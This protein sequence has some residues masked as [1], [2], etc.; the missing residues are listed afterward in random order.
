MKTEDH[1]KIAALHQKDMAASLAR[2]YETLIS[3]MDEAIVLIPSRGPSRRGKA[4]V[5]ADLKAYLERTE[6][7]QVIEYVHAFEEVE[8]AGDWAFEWGAYRGTTVPPG[9]PPV[10]ETGKIF[11]ILKKQ[12]DG[13][14]KVYRAMEAPE[15]SES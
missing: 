9:K 13:S 3:L 5:A 15:G 4:A 7:W 8:V 2:D 14:W 12:P 1:L 11:R 10:R 6:G